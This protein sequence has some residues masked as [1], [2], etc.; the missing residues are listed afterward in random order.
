MSKNELPT[1]LEITS[2]DK[3]VFD[4]QFVSFSAAEDFYFWWVNRS[5][6][7]QGGAS[8]TRADK[9]DG[10]RATHPLEQAILTP[11]QQRLIAD[12][13]TLAARDGHLPLGTLDE[14]IAEVS[15]RM[16]RDG[17]R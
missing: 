6:L 10:W 14:A 3:I 5:A 12:R 15:E 17:V 4:G 13:L 2:Y 16:G 7:P 8:L 11:V 9:P 1:R